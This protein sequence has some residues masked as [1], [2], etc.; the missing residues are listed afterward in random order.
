MIALEIII[1]ETVMVESGF[2]KSFLKKI[3]SLCQQ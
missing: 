3:E 2:K 1:I